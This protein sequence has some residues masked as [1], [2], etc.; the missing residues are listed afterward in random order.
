MDSSAE[1]IEA[2]PLQ[3]QADADTVLAYIATR[4]GLIVSA[5]C[6]RERAAIAAVALTEIGRILA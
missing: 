1:P 6:H 4:F 3:P 5:D 2:A